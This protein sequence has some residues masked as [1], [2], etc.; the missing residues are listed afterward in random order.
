MY[1]TT[2]AH[3]VQSHVDVGFTARPWQ[4]KWNHSKQLSHRAQ[5]S[6]RSVGRTHDGDDAAHGLSTSAVRRRVKTTSLYLSA[7]FWV[8][9]AGFTS[10]ATA[11]AF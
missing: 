7:S 6:T 9:D 10:F 1:Y 5:S 3:R 11:S 2:A 8:R 4:T